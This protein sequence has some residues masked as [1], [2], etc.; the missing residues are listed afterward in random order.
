M[1]LSTDADSSAPALS[2]DELDELDAILDDL[3]QRGTGDIPQWEFCDGF[4]TALVCTRRT[5][6]PA[7]YLPVLL[8]DGAPAADALAPEALGFADAAQ[9]QRFMALWQRRWDEVTRQLDT[10]VDSLDQDEALV[11]ATFDLRGA[12]AMLPEDQRAEAQ[13]Q[14]PVPAFAQIW[15]LGFLCA[16]DVW[17]EEWAAPRDKETAQW[18]DEALGHIE[19][20]TQDDTGVP[21]YSMFDDDAPPSVSQARLDA[22]G[23][24][25]WA[26]YD[27]RQLWHS[28]GP[29][30][31]PVVKP[32]APGRNELCWC[33]SGKKF[34]K[35]HGA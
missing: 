8:G 17:P 24:A 10:E 20:L 9:Q 32:A 2:S 21:A 34:K 14:G 22:F 3:R 5:V 7:E 4:L 30:Q 28:L 26:V 11:P 35:C 1:T 6:P 33:G 23:E 12:L 15:A 31:E 16:V 27:L 19:A 25:I 13:E 29:R 18:L